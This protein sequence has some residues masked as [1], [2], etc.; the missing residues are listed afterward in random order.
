VYGRFCG[1]VAAF[2]FIVIL[3]SVFLIT[4]WYLKATICVLLKVL[5]VSDTICG[6]HS[7]KVLKFEGKDWMG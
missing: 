2:N 1:I 5:D 4:A 7:L 3:N 6:T